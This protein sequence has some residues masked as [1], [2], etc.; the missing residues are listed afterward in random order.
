MNLGFEHSYATLPDRFYAR[1]AAGRRVGTASDRLQRAA[2]TRARPR[3]CDAATQR[4]CN[5]F[6]QRS[7]GGCESARNGLRG[8]PVRALRAAARGWPRSAA[9]RAARSLGRA[10]RRP[11]Q[12]LGP[13]AVLAVGRRTGGHGSDAARIPDQ[14]GD[15]RP[16]HPDDTIAGR[17]R[18]GRSRD[19]RGAAARRRADARRREPR[20]RGDV[21]VLRRPRRP[22]RRARARGLRDRPPLPR[23]AQGTDSGTRPA[24]PR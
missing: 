5:I 11:A 12:G 9:G 15:A 14:R 10:A 8:P 4:R 17:R 23:S 16:R 7:A 21:R 3:S 20:A 24:T 22:G 1:R 2:G 6:R 13:H 18:D 19:A